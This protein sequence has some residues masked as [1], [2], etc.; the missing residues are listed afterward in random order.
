MTK[1]ELSGQEHIRLP[2]KLILECLIG[3]FIAFLMAYG[4]GMT[5]DALEFVYGNY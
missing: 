1:N 4:I 2:Y 5:V 3:L